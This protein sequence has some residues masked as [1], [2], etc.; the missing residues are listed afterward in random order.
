MAMKVVKLNILVTM[1]IDM[2]SDDMNEGQ[3]YMDEEGNLYHHDDMMEG[4]EDDE[5]HH[6]DNDSYGEEGS[7]GVSN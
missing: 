4:D 6:M 7:P 1:I 5:G 3:Q 2:G